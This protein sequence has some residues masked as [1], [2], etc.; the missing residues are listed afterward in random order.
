MEGFAID[1]SQSGSD[2]PGPT[3]TYM[4]EVMYEYLHELLYMGCIYS[5][6]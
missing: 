6:M 3:Y 1:A 4:V 2:L 5:F